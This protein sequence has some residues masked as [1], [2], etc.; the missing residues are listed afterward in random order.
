[1]SLHCSR[2]PRLLAAAILPALATAGSVVT[3]AMGLAGSVIS[4]VNMNTIDRL[5]KQVQG[6]VFI[7]TTETLRIFNLVSHTSGRA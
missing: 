2:E 7:V 4:I 3:A 5:S 1:M 6:M